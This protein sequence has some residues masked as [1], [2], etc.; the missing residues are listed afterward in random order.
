MQIPNDMVGGLLDLASL[1]TSV[2]PDHTPHA[3]LEVHGLEFVILTQ[4]QFDKLC[5]GTDKDICS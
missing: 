1:S 4:R 2:D 3:K 5:K